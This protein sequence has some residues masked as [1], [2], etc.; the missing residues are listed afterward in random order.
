[1]KFLNNLI[2][3]IVFII[4]AM[5]VFYLAKQ[6]G[7]DYDPEDTSMWRSFFRVIGIAVI[8]VGAYFIWKI[9]FIRKKEQ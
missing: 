4:W 3:L 7:V 1:M 8:F 6:M 2:R 9:N 5:L